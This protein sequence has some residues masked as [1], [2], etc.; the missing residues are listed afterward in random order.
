MSLLIARE[1][2]ESSAVLLIPHDPGEPLVHQYSIDLTLLSG[3]ERIQAVR[4]EL[5]SR[6]A[7]ARLFHD[8]V[9][10]AR[11]VN[12]VAA[13]TLARDDAEFCTIDACS[14]S[15]GLVEQNQIL[16]AGDDDGRHFDLREIVRR[17]V[18]L[19]HHEV[20]LRVLLDLVRHLD[21]ELQRLA[22]ALRSHVRAASDQHPDPARLHSRQKT[23]DPAIAEPV[24]NDILQV[25]LVHE[26]DHVVA[27]V[28]VVELVHPRARAVV[29]RVHR[30][31]REV[32]SQLR[33][34]FMENRVILPVAVHHDKRPAAARDLIIQLDPININKHSTSP[35]SSKKR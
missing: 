8:D 26:G 22:D 11:V 12:D 33:D 31:Y 16:F 24:E 6:L 29:P 34:R 1:P 10:D 28:S 17:D 13:V 25:E 15:L 7:D 18:R 21:K 30:V 35:F 20:Q 14:D 2:L 4:I 27:H 5:R 9:C 19:C 32:L 3:F 23:D